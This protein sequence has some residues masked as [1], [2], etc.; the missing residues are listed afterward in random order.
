MP[1]E[2]PYEPPP[3][4]QEPPP[5]FSLGKLLTLLSMVLL[6]VPAGAIAALAIC[7][8]ADA[9]RLPMPVS[10]VIGS[11]AGLLMTALVIISAVKIYRELPSR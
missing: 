10:L 1:D 5:K 3:S 9:A 8:V 4:L 6:S 11:I 7:G 2:N